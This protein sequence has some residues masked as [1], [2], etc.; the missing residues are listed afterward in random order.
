MVIMG[1]TT[2]AEVDKSCLINHTDDDSVG[3]VVSLSVCR[4][5]SP[6]FRLGNWKSRDD[7]EWYY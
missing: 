7:K 6:I 5:K 3:K 1:D 4:C 2:G